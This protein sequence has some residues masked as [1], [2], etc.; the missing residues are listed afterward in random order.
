M[1]VT[2]QQIEMLANALTEA[3][4]SETDLPYPIGEG[5]S[6]DFYEGLINGL[7]LGHQFLIDSDSQN[8]ELSRL[9]S[10]AAAVASTRYLELKS[11]DD[12][13]LST[14]HIS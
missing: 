8:A 11:S 4:Q 14:D 9:F 13:V 3:G 1:K 7:V 5:E 6:V 10:V 2:I 12:E